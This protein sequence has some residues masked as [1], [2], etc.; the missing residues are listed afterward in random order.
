MF[1]FWN[2]LVGNAGSSAPMLSLLTIAGC[3]TCWAHR[4]ITDIHS[5]DLEPA[6]HTNT[7]DTIGYWVKLVIAIAVKGLANKRLIDLM[8]AG[9][10][11][12]SQPKLTPAG[13]LAGCGVRLIGGCQ[14]HGAALR[15]RRGTALASTCRCCCAAWPAPNPHAFSVTVLGN[16]GKPATG[17]RA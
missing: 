11:L 14:M 2:K 9:L 10:R 3:I 5:A 13:N 4:A 1:R 17:P 12:Q 8:A 6:N 15:T 7:T 16:R